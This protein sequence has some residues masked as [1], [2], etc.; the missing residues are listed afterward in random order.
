MQQNFMQLAIDQAT[1]GKNQTYKNPLVGAVIV[2][3]N[4]IISTGAH[5]KYGDPHAEV[6][7][8]KNC[9]SSEELFNSTL[10]VT[11]EPC[12]HF[13]KQP[14]CTQAIIQSGIKKVIIG[15]LDPNPL[16]AGSGKQYLENNGIEVEVIT[17]SEQVKHLNKFY[18][19]F[20]EHGRPYIT[21]KQ[22]QTLDGKVSIDSKT[23]TSITEDK[24]KRQVEKERGEYQAILVGSQTVLADNPTLFTSLDIDHPPIR[25]V[26]DRR[27]RLF[28]HQQLTLFSSM[29]APVW[30]FTEKTVEQSL[31][32]HVRVFTYKIFTLD[33]LM[34]TLWEAGI[35]S[36]YVEGGPKIHD[37][38]LESDYWEDVIT[39]LAPKLIGGTSLA[40]FSSARL[41][42]KIVELHDLEIDRLDDTLRI[43][44]VKS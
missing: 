4:K 5:L 29:S 3:N 25:I 34:T 44:G 6:N 35:Q 28:S 8:I 39:Y 17:E 20:F 43:K 1:K 19:Y 37:A 12:N 31:P 42:E 32:K 41:P 21:L 22:A 2:K 10:Y 9:T 36:V 15:Q 11:L 27:G 40:A 30:I 23:R 13:G 18:N 38:F 14:P 26:L 24:A 7:A 33:V 16:V